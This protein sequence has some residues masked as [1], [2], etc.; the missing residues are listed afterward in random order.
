[1]IK[2]YDVLNGNIQKQRNNQNISLSLKRTR[3]IIEQ[4]NYAISD[5]DRVTQQNALKLMKQMK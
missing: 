3:K 4:V 1:M 2:R 5:L